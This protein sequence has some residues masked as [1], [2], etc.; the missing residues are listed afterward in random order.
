MANASLL[1]IGPCGGFCAISH[2]LLWVSSNWLPIGPC[3]GLHAI[4][5][6][7]D[8]SLL[9]VGPCK[10]LDDISYRLL[11]ADLSPSVGAIHSKC[12][13]LQAFRGSHPSCP[14]ISFMQQLIVGSMGQCEGLYEISYRL[15]LANSSPLVEAIHSKHGPLQGI[16]QQPS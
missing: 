5:L 1:P 9:P 3:E 10:G 2:R 4:S 6:Q 12:G 15:L 7:A 8:L 16:S 11:S 13:P 14:R